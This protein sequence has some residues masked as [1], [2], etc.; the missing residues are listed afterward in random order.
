[1]RKVRGVVVAPAAAFLS[2]VRASVK[3][4]FVLFARG[5]RQLIRCRI[6]PRLKRDA[7]RASEFP[8][9]N[10]S[11]RTITRRERVFFFLPRHGPT[12]GRARS[13]FS[14]DF[15]KRALTVPLRFYF[16]TIP[17][18]GDLRRYRVRVL[19]R[20]FDTT[21]NIYISRRTENDTRVHVP[22]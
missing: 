19:A 11:D 16:Y 6:D 22:R 4:N 21:R 9:L 14:R 13:S 3:L 8:I 20:T 7:G 17:I 10:L 18:T 12:H 1:M 5:S 2:H 15:R